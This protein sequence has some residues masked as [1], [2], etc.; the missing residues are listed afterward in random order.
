MSDDVDLSSIH[1]A[2]RR[3]ARRGKRGG[4]KRRERR[5]AA[6]AAQIIAMRTRLAKLFT[7]ADP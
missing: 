4:R 7:K 2:R 5:I 6:Q 3:K 1:P